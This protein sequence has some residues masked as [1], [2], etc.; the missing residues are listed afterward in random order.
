MRDDLTGE[1][2]EACARVLIGGASIFLALREA[3]VGD[4]HAARLLLEPAMIGAIAAGENRAVA[5]AELDRC[6]DGI[7]AANEQGDLVSAGKVLEHF[8]RS[9]FVH[10]D[11]APL[12][13]VML[14]LGGMMN[15]AMILS[16]INGQEGNARALQAKLQETAKDYRH[17]TGLVARGAADEASAFWLAYMRRSARFLAENG[18]AG[19]RVRYH[20]R[21]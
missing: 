20:K 4:L 10:S 16:M 15:E 13:L 18:M 9:M 3:T 21:A 2:F 14:M 1:A 19:N 11:N 8:Y 17:L 12:E 6:V 7:E 5:A